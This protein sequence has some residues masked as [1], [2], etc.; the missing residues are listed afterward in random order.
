MSIRISLGA[1]VV[2]TVL[3]LALVSCDD[4]P[5]DDA[6]DGVTCS[7]HGTCVV[8]D[9]TARCDCAPGYDEEGLACVEQVS[10]GDADIDDDGDAD[11]DADADG[12]GDAEADGDADGDSDHDGDAD[13]DVDTVLASLLAHWRFDEGEGTTAF[14]SSGHGNDGEISGAEWNTGVSGDALD[15]DTVD[16]VEVAGW[17]NAP[18]YATDEITMTAWYNW[19]GSTTVGGNVYII[20][21]PFSAED[22]LFG[23]YIDSGPS[24]IRC[25]VM[26]ESTRVV[27]RDTSPVDMWTH[28][29]CTYDSAQLRLFVNGESVDEVALTGELVE[30]TSSLYLGSW[31]GVRQSFSG[32]LDE[33]KIYARALSAEEIAL[34]HGS[35]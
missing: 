24:Q 18:L 7:F 26:T 2:G 21:H 9:G 32:L 8:E 12:D 10:D 11:A 23:L 31:N 35:L 33:L 19:D 17:D 3:G 30:E 22:T 29:A 1:F 5:S 34:E 14:D 6:C 15:F 20:G 25:S 4:E 27:V 28:A 13:S 16:R